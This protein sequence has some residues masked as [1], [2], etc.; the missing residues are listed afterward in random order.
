[1]SKREKYWMMENS[2]MAAFANFRISACAGV[3]EA[4]YPCTG[5]HLLHEFQQDTQEHVIHR[6]TAF[7]LIHA[8]SNINEITPFH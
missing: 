2:R 5:A 7:Q 3:K 6:C 8:A 1:M 4:E